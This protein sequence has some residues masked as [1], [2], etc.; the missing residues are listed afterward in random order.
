[1]RPRWSSASWIGTRR[2]ATCSSSR[3]HGGGHH[4]DE[5]PEEEGGDRR[6]RA[7][8]RSRCWNSSPAST[9][10]EGA[11]AAHPDRD[12]RRLCQVPAI[13]SGAHWDMQQEV[14]SLGRS[15]SKSGSA[16]NSPSWKVAR[17][18]PSA[19]ERAV[20]LF[21]RTFVPSRF[22]S[23]CW[24]LEVCVLLRQRRAKRKAPLPLVSV[25]LRPRAPSGTGSQLHPPPRNDGGCRAWSPS[26]QPSGCPFGFPMAA[27]LWA[28][29]SF[30]DFQRLP[31][32]L[33]RLQSPARSKA[34][35]MSTR[36]AS[37]QKSCLRL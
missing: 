3:P 22:M 5:V 30:R 7:S 13:P 27:S 20:F 6:H 34:K 10:T 24:Q 17:G 32:G 23:S 12:R 16:P 28:I 11:Q 37:E 4:T 15:R 14:P 25:H 19:S 9:V 35:A 2:S 26:R 18:R 33:R 21:A 36:N 29:S 1:M 31:Q 8:S